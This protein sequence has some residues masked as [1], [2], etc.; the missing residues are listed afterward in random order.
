MRPVAEQAFFLSSYR[1]GFRLWA[2]SDLPLAR[3]LWSDPQ[4]TGFIGGPFSEDQVRTRLDAEI[5]TARE[6]GMQYW[7]LLATGDFVGCCGLHPRPR[8]GTL[9]LGFHLRPDF[10]GRGLAFEAASTVV[11]YAFE[12][13]AARELFAGHHPD[14]DASRRLL[15]RLGFSYSHCELYPPTGREHPSYLLAAPALPEEAST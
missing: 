6:H 11:A 13:L 7:P 4:V 2:P 10:W 15:L 14:N 5:A 12:R 3:G 1:I 9:E 8:P